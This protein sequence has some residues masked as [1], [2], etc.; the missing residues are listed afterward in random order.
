MAQPGSSSGIYNFAMTN[1][2][3]IVE[4]FDRIQIEPP[5]ITRHKM[6][7]A[8]SSI[9]LELIEW[10]DAGFL[11]WKTVTGTINLVGNQATYVL[12]ASLVT[13]E[14]LWYSNVNGNGPG[15]NQDRIMVPITRTDYA[16]LSNKLQ[17]GIPTQYWFQMLVPPQVTISQVPNV[18]APNYVLNWFGLQQMQDANLGGG[19]T[20]DVPRRAYDAL[21]AGLAKRLAMKFK[22]ELYEARKAD[23]EAAF[24]G[25]ARR[26]QE[27]GPISYLPNVGVYGRMS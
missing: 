13:L 11:F 10:E 21:C 23:A 5:E 12:P 17:Q 2:S 8:R 6:M 19:E 25:L 1:G 9:N 7:S 27:P 16:A 14:E 22:P 24:M 20:P 4:A 18:G 3:M 15:V 26:D